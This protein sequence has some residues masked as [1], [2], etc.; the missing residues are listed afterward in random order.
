MLKL[1]FSIL[2]G[3]MFIRDLLNKLSFGKCIVCNKNIYKDFIGIKKVLIILFDN[4]LGLWIMLSPYICENFH[5][6]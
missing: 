3:E 4:F 2:N 1:T 5:F 6:V